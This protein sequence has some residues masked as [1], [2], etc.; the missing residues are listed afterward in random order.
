[1]NGLPRSRTAAFA[2]NGKLWIFALDREGPELT[3]VRTQNRL[4]STV[5]KHSCV[6]LS[7][8]LRIMDK[9]RNK[10]PFPLSLNRLKRHG[11]WCQRG[12]ASTHIHTPLFHEKSTIFGVCDGCIRLNLCASAD[13]QQRNGVHL[14]IAPSAP[15]ARKRT[16]TGRRRRR[17]G[18]PLPDRIRLKGWSGARPP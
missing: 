16:R 2:V 13:P 11:I 4:V 5:S 10:N 15:R 1:M 8:I 18:R 9:R 7:T 6:T 12:L 14:N 17:D 3:N